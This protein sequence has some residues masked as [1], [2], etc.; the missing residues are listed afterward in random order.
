M[1]RKL[2]LSGL[3]VIGLLLVGPQKAS[4]DQLF[5]CKN[6]TITNQPLILYT[7][8][9]TCPPG[10]TATSINVAGTPGLPAGADYQCVNTA[11]GGGPQ[12]TFEPSQSG[13]TFGSAISTTGSQFTS[14][15]LQP[16]IYQI[17]LSGAKLQPLIL[18]IP[19]FPTLTAAWGGPSPPRGKLYSMRKRLLRLGSLILL[20]GTDLFRLGRPT[21]PRPHERGLLRTRHHE[22][23]IKTASAATPT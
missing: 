14:F 17:H 13:V 15:L 2:L 7:A 8:T 19:R 12:L 11:T 4:A 21:P 23:A 10:S 16:G 22:S 9:P 18:P 6:P 5:Y 20:E 1:L 3:A